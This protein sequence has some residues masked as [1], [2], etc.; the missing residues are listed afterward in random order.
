MKI[1]TSLTGDMVF[2][3]FEEIKYYVTLDQKILFDKT[4]ATEIHDPDNLSSGDLFTDGGD[5]IYIYLYREGENI[6]CY[7]LRFE[8]HCLLITDELNNNFKILKRAPI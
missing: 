3:V 6:A 1:K 4:I 8:Q 2:E 5:S 7:D